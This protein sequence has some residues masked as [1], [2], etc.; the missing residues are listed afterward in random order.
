MPCF[1]LV[2]TTHEYNFTFVEGPASQNVPPVGE[3]RPSGADGLVLKR[4][5]FGTLLAVDTPGGTHRA[6]AHV[7]AVPAWKRLAALVL[8]PLHVALLAAHI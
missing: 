1:P 4:T 3:T 8:V 5:G 6:A 2:A 7:H